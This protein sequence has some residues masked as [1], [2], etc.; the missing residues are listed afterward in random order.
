MKWLYQYQE[1]NYMNE[2][3]WRYIFTSFRL[4]DPLLTD[5]QDERAAYFD[6]VAAQQSLVRQ[7]LAD[8]VGKL[9][10]AA[11]E[12]LYNFWSVKDRNAVRPSVIFYE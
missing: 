11:E 10:A 1:L 3:Y 8:Y 7:E 12:Y 9:S 2:D 4:K 5:G 6:T